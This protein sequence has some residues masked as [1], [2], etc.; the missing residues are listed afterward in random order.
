MLLGIMLKDFYITKKNNLLCL[1][2]F[3]VYGVIGIISD[4]KSVWMPT[5]YTAIFISLQCIT[6]LAFDEQSGWNT[7]ALTMP[8]GRDI[9]VKSKYLFSILFLLLYEVYTAFFFVIMNIIKGDGYGGI[10][11]SLGLS[12][13]ASI[14]LIS[15]SIPIMIKFGTDKGRV[16]LSV[17]FFSF[18][19][20]AL[21]V[22][23]YTAMDKLIQ[24]DLLHWL[25]RYRHFLLPGGFIFL[26]F[27]LFI[28]YEIS[29]NCM[30]KK[31]F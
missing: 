1:L 12:F 20:L 9:L 3:L 29:L 15:L 31:E 28:S 13:S 7:Y 22:Y 6:S 16:L 19:I 5:L 27:L 10:Y 18:G 2:I 11:L 24:N 23:Q 25:I 26:L 8:L 4:N 17:G 21:A 30:R 14:F